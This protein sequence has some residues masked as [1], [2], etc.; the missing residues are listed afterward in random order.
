MTGPVAA[1]EPDQGWH[2][3]PPGFTVYRVQDEWR[4]R[5]GIRV[6]RPRRCWYRTY[7]AEWD[8]CRRAVRA[9]TRN[10]LLVKAG[11]QLRKNH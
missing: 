10:G 2:D 1:V 9:Y 7:Q 8:G 3:W 11:R 4:P 5:R 6:R